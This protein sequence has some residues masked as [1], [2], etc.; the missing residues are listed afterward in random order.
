MSRAQRQPPCAHPRAGPP[1]HGRHANAPQKRGHVQ[2]AEPEPQAAANDGTT[3]QP[4]ATP[5]GTAARDQLHPAGDAGWS[6]A[7]TC[8]CFEVTGP[9]A[10]LGRH[11]RPGPLPVPLPDGRHADR[12][13]RATYFQPRAAGSLYGPADGSP[14]SRWHQ[15]ADGT[16]IT[17][18]S[19][20]GTELLGF[21]RYATTPG[22]ADG[23]GHS[24][25]TASRYLCVLHIAL[26]PG[27]PLGALTAAVR[28]SPDDEA[29]AG[30][31]ERYAGLAGSGFQIPPGVRRALSVTMITF[32]G[33]LQSPPGAPTQWT[34]ANGWLWTAASATPLQEL[35]PDPED[36]RVLDGLVYL[37]SSWRALVLRDGVGFLGLVPDTGSDTGFFAWGEG[38]VRSLYTDVALLAALERDALDDFA[39]RLAQIG[40]RFERSAE[41]RRLVN[42]VTEFRNL[43]WWEAVTRHGNANSILDQLHGAHRTPRLFNRVVADL[44]AFRQQVEAQALE[45]SVRVQVAEEG[46]SRRFDHAAAIAA[47]AFAV[48]ALVFAAL[49]VPDEEVT[50][51]IHD[52]PAWAVIV[53]GLGALLAG[54]IAGAAGG[55]WI[56]GRAPS[57]PPRHH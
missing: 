5:G 6:R 3:T 1:R 35:S 20:L 21:P 17:E 36:P 23:T 32:R 51:G 18:G 48:P 10:I 46:R 11:W 52:V 14:A 45:E 25:G 16:R 53:I 4:P 9:A 55:R 37:S 15:A 24:A 57:G 43:F 12:A 30:R 27:D 38:Y 39:N 22:A 26:D 13:A 7:I 49:T 41:F 2:P 42:E 50:S 56:S 29:C 28:L 33:E 54:A 8:L 40:N 47:I 44:E 31:R 34:A 19:V